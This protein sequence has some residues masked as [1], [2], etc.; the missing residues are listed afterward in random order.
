[1]RAI[2]SVP[3]WA[4][5][6]AGI[7]GLATAIGLRAVGMRFIAYFIRELIPPFPGLKIDYA[8]Y[9]RVPPEARAW[10]HASGAIASSS[11]YSRGFGLGR[12]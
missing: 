1:M 3:R 6:A 12:Q 10:M 11:A 2:R 7:A 8:T 5:A 9:L 4:W